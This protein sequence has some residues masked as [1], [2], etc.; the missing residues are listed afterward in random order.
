MSEASTRSGSPSSSASISQAPFSRRGSADT[1]D[2]ASGEPSSASIDSPPR[3]ALASGLPTQVEDAQACSVGVAGSGLLAGTSPMKKPCPLSPAAIGDASR[4]QPMSTMVTPVGSPTKR[5]SLAGLAMGACGGQLILPSMALLGEAFQPSPAGTPV[6]TPVNKYTVVGTS[7][8]HRS[9]AP[10][11]GCIATGD[12][13]QRTPL[14]S[15]MADQQNAALK[16]WLC[17]SPHSLP[18]GPELT[19][20]LQAALPEAYND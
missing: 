4:R 18:S 17:G 2:Y 3:A 19:V 6:A 15:P 1:A 20:L 9:S 7:P 16:S 12:A 10:F 8:Q 11:S 5:Y 13:S 14:A